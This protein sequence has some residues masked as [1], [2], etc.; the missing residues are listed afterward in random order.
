MRT[1]T[2]K[3]YSWAL[4][5]AESDKAPYWIG[6]LFFLEIALFIP[7]DAILVFFCLQNR[8]KTFLY[9]TIA[10]IASTASGLIGYV[11]GHFLWDLVGPYV[12]PH[13]ISTPSFDRISHHF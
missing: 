5:K 1:Q 3:L 7:L 2:A 13:L 10:T 4:Q 9:A 12:V 8:Q 6:L 11:F